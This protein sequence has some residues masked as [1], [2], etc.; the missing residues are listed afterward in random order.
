MINKRT[1]FGFI[2]VLAALLI[3]GNQALANLMEKKE[4][5]ETLYLYDLMNTHLIE[6]ISYLNFLITTPL[7]ILVGAL[8]LLFI[9]FGAIRQK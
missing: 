7:Y 3:L 8:G 1:I 5:S 6:G 4:A 2:C 9:I